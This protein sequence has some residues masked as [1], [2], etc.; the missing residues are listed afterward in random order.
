MLFP[1]LREMV[2]RE[3]RGRAD[4]GGPESAMNQGHLCLDQPAYE[5]IA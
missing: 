2:F 4:K 3:S 1:H 5:N